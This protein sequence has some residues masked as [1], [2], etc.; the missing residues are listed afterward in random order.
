MFVFW[1]DKAEW[2]HLDV[3]VKWFLTKD[4]EA[5]REIDC[6]QTMGSYLD[7]SSKYCIYEK[8][9]FVEK[10]KNRIVYT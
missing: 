2:L 10:K 9:L 5:C 7:V 4:T 8:C 1:K 3:F 6:K